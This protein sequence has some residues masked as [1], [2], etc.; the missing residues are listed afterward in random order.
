MIFIQIFRSDL[1][2]LKKVAVR[3]NGTKFAQSLRVTVC[4]EVCKRAF[5]WDFNMCLKTEIRLLEDLMVR[6]KEK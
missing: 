5:L 1:W 2:N 6:D 4:P 3:V